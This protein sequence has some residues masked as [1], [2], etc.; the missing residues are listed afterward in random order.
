MVGQKRQNFPFPSGK[1]ADAG[2][3]ERFTMLLREIESPAM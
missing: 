1:L 3:E 2:E